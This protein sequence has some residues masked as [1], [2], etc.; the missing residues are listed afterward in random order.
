MNSYPVI[1]D[2]K[3]IFYYIISLPGFF[4]VMVTGGYLT[5]YYARKNIIVHAILVGASTCG[6]ALYSS[7]N[8]DQLTLTGIIFF[9]TG[10]I[11]TVIGSLYWQK[12]NPN[13]N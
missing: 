9:I 8:E 4:L 13:N 6:L 5:S 7:I 10:V 11:F 3:Q 12:N 1:K 2:Y